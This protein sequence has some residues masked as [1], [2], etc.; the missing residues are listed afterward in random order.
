MAVAALI[1]FGSLV[2]DAAWRSPNHPD[3]PLVAARSLARVPPPRP[4]P[5]APIVLPAVP[6]AVL[7]P[8]EMAARPMTPLEAPAP[9]RTVVV[10]RRV[11]PAIE[12]LTIKANPYR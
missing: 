1:A 3:P 9:P 8:P 10:R 5:S 4:A 2:T 6:S 7:A 11:R 12:A